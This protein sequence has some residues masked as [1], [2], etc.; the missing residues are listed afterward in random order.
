MAKNFWQKSGKPILAL[1]PMA[2][3][4][5]SAFRQICREYGADVLYS[6][7]TSADGLFYGGKKTLELLKFN[8]KERPL[9]IQLFGKRPE[10]FTAA[11]AQ[12]ENSG[13]SGI[14]INF[15]CPAKKVVA[16]GGGVTLMKNLDKCYEIIIHTLKGTSL[17]VS[18]KIRTSI[19]DRGGKITAIDFIKRINALPVAAIMIHG[20]SYEQEFAG[21]VDYE[22]IKKAKT[23]VSVPVLAN[24]GINKPEE[25]KIMLEKTKADGLGL[26]RGVRGRPWLF[27]Q[28][29]DYLGA[30]R[31]Q[32][33]HWEQ[34]KKVMLRHAELAFQSK[35]EY[36]LVELRKHLAWYVSG[37]PDASKLRQKLV[38]TSSISSIV[39]TLNLK[40]PAQNSRK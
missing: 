31:Y 8:K 1:A 14:D 9:V 22:M 4:T 20:R 27:Q 25:A 6:E 24:G 12:V 18:V 34:I 32:E 7:M 15:G 23:M 40:T 35:G 5:D 21:P 37:Q 33:F 39:K 2:G 30:G 28:I 3:I 26:A 38:I 19:N 36:G 29:K 16:H 11:A 10:K 13:A 17:P